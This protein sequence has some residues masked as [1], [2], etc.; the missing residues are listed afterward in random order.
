MSGSRVHQAA[1][2]IVVRAAA[3]TGGASCQQAADKGQLLVDKLQQP[4]LPLPPRRTAG[5]CTIMLDRLVKM[6][7]RL[8]RLKERLVLGLAAFAIVFTLFL[9]MDLQLD[10]GYS[11]HHLLPSHGRI[12]MA[13]DPQRDTVY[14][15]FRWV[16]CLIL[17]CRVSFLSIVG[18]ETFHPWVYYSSGRFVLGIEH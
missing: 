9:V 3:A 15:N 14:N 16:R 17:G 6:A 11:G 5:G 4:E 8:V 10:L 12:R 2:G 13:E 1:S 7:G 18:T